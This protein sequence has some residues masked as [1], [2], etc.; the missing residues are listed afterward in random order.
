VKPLQ[1]TITG[2]TGSIEETK[3]LDVTCTTTGSRPKATLQ[4]RIGQKDV[5]SNA[6]ERSSYFTAS[7][8]HTVTSDLTYSVGK[9]H[10]GQVLTCKAVN[11]AA[12]SGVLTSIT[13]NVT[14]KFKKYVFIQN[15]LL[16]K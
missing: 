11:V 5:T 3:P 6:T 10:N 14:C 1:P 15:V 12:S 8:T 16:Y 13:L 2:Y 9:N 7:D 4:W